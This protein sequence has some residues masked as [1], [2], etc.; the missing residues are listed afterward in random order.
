MTVKHPLVLAITGASGS[1][2]AV[3]L[4]QQLALADETV[5]V[6]MSDSAGLVLHQ[7]LGIALPKKPLQ[8]GKE[9]DEI[10]RTI[11]ETLLRYS[12]ANEK[13]WSPIDEKQIAPYR[14]K[15]HLH[16]AHDFMT[17]IASGSH[18]TRGMIVCPC[19]GSTLSGLVH[20]HGKDLIQ[21]AAEVHLKEHRKLILVPRETPMSVFQLENLHRAA[22]AGAVVLPAMPG[23]Y[24]GVRSLVDLVDFVV[25][26]ILDHLEIEHRL[27]RR[28]CEFEEGA[29]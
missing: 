23:W 21:R 14:D 18:R 26:R 2:Y 28:W 25:A 7:E 3:R 15:I 8:K 16:H 4:L 13:D 17:P 9:T 11:I 5:H 19:S 6:V 29:S 10:D 22:L 1:V 20:A 12:M 27:V 24:H